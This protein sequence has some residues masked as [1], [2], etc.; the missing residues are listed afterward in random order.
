MQNAM[1]LMS[2][3]LPILIIAT[4]LAEPKSTK[5]TETE[6]QLL[7]L[8]ESTQKEISDLGAKLETC[9]TEER[10]FIDQ[11][12][13]DIKN[14]AELSRLTILLEDAEASG[15]ELRTN[16]IR[17]ALLQLQDRLNEKEGETV[18]SNSVIPP[19]L[20]VKPSEANSKK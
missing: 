19:A 16:Q 14:R 11:Q 1:R 12:I 3:F 9:T 17:M 10:R 8:K 15:N 2:F 13:T 4:L 18:K 6:R 7:Q 20:K 5:I